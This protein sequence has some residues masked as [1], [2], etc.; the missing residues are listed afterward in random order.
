MF[1]HLS[2][3]ERLGYVA[4]AAI[5]LFGMSFVIG[6]SLHRPAA[7]ELH[8]TTQPLVTF[9][10]G[11]PRGRTGTTASS[12]ASHSGAVIIDVAGAVNTPGVVELPAGSRVMDA[13]RAAGGFS[14]DANSDSVNLAAKVTDGLQVYVPRRS[15]SVTTPLSGS[16]MNSSTSRRS[17]QPNAVIDI[18]SADATQLTTLPGIGPSMAQ[19]II[20]YRIDHGTFRSVDDLAA[21]QGFGKKR[22]DNI[23]E[24]LTAN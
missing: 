6:R 7:I 18:N 15:G 1:M 13:V 22:L 20:E 14:D 4:I 8:E 21:V 5:L 10:H 2:P 23:R 16:S 17:K 24:W 12:D 3:K 19:R 9:D 11:T